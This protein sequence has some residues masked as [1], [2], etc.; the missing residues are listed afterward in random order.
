MTTEHEDPATE[1]IRIRV[2]A[3]PDK[4]PGFS[5]HNRAI[6]AGYRCPLCGAAKSIEE[7]IV[8]VHLPT[9][10]G[11]LFCS[12][13]AVV[14]AETMDLL[15]EV[16]SLLAGD[17]RV[18][19][20]K[21]TSDRADTLD[22]RSTMAPGLSMVQATRMQ[23]PIEEARAAVRLV[24][25]TGEPALLILGRSAVLVSAVW[26]R[27][28]DRLIA[29]LDAGAPEEQRVARGVEDGPVEDWRGHRPGLPT[30]GGAIVRCSVCRAPIGWKGELM[31]GDCIGKP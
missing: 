3:C 8:H 5:V 11:E 1:A 6:A 26:R 23:T 13:G 17:W 7:P 9:A 18:L 30:D 27:S 4:R 22:R 19:P 28:S 12:C 2:A 24:T 16:G 31:T 14:S 10:P 29:A 20:E 25:S 21:A 15:L